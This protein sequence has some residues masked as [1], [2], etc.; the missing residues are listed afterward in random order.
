MRA[1]Q[2]VLPVKADESYVSVV[3]VSLVGIGLTVLFALLLPDW[4]IR[5][6]T[7]WSRRL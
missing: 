7:K 2:Q 5:E 1:E 6:W 3:R 4:V